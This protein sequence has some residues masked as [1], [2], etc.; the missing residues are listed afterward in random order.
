MI[1]Y[2]PNPSF[3]P[4]GDLNTDSGLARDRVT[5]PSIKKRAAKIHPPV[6]KK[7]DYPRRTKIAAA[8][9]ERTAERID[10]KHE[11]GIITSRLAATRGFRPGKRLAEY[12]EPDLER[13]LPPAKDLKNC[14]SAADRIIAAIAKGETITIRTD[15]DVDG[16]T[17][18]SLMG[19]YLTR[20]GAKVL[21]E[22]P[23]RFNEKEGYGLKPNDIDQARENGSTLVIAVDIGTTDIEAL[24]HASDKALGKVDTI[25]IDHHELRG[26]ANPPADHFINPHQDGDG[27][28][29]KSM[30]AVGLC[31]QV[32]R[33]ISEKLR[34]SQAHPDLKE[35]ALAIDPYEDIDLVGFGTVADVVPLKGPNHAVVKIGL[36]R[37]D[38][39]NKPGLVALK[40]IAGVT[41]KMVAADIAF[42]LAPR[43]NALSRMG[44]REDLGVSGGSLGVTLCRTT[45][46]AEGEQIA[47]LAHEMNT[48]RKRVERAS[49]KVALEKLAKRKKLPSVI[50]LQDENFHEGVNG[51]VAARLVD[52]YFRPAVV[53]SDSGKG[54]ARS[55]PGVHVK[56]LLG[57]AEKHLSSLGG[58]AQAAG[59]RVKPDEFD[60]FQAIFEKRGVTA[61]KRVDTK[62][63]QRVDIEVTLEELV[64]EGPALIE[65]LNR[66]GP[67]G[68]GNPE[69][70]LLVRNVQVV[71]TQIQKDL[72]RKHRFRSGSTYIQGVLWHQPD[73][74]DLA[75]GK[76]VD[77]VCRPALDKRA[78]YNPD[79]NHIQLEVFAAQAAK[80]SK[81]SL[82]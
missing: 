67:F 17:S 80:G 73:H 32:V 8:K 78:N 18:G 20:L 82:K 25:V 31:L 39:T 76:Y 74:P 61:L 40:E 23:D 36:E 43:V 7:I 26:A 63:K 70:R 62:P 4:T 6:V 30:C 10:A 56:N 54:S 47:R 55:I 11:L 45:D 79:L 24:E 5:R 16:I 22:T 37:F 77:L 66:L 48:E 41:D 2:D 19:N 58:H 9:I 35:R 34:A 14:D 1:T 53:V 52:R 42:G 3:H 65:K 50:A 69:P 64:A 12:L 29:K 13:D 21:V 81:A 68:G 44:R 49:L 57:K 27:F 33:R 15:F 72:H 75:N 59:L 28:A 38:N 71:T 51:I 46:S 60:A